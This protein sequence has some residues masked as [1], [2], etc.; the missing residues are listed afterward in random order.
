M[1]RKDRNRAADGGQPGAPERSAVEQ[2]NGGGPAQDKVSAA[3]TPSG[4]GGAHKNQ[5]HKERRFGHN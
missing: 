1:G 3:V 2:D 5:K 4:F